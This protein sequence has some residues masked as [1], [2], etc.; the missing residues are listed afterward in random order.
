MTPFVVRVLYEVLSRTG[1][2]PALAAAD[3]PD[4]RL[5]ELVEGPQ[6]LD[7]GRAL[8]LGC[9]AG[10]NTLYLARHGWEAIGIDFV[11]RAIEKARSK[12]V[13]AV[14]PARFLRGDVSRLADLD[15]GDGFTLI[16]DS[17]CYKSLSDVQRNAYAA[18]VTQVA[19]PKALLLIAGGTRRP[20]TATGICEQDAHRFAGWE[21]HANALVPVE[22]IMRHTRIPYR[23]KARIASGR[24]Q[25][26]RL[27]LSR[28]QA[29]LESG[30]GVRLDD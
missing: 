6:R 4:T 29:T 15:I 12:A 9:G 21:L 27:E 1:L 23:M 26:R 30:S 22:E 16:I 2:N 25:I 8:D 11:G 14:A 24:S 7:P 5:V 3:I 28:N 20:G 17:G 19:A 10:R 13:D 18:G